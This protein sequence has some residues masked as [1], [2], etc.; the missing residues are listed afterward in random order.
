MK[1][2]PPSLNQI[3]SSLRIGKQGGEEE[4]R[5]RLRAPNF[6]PIDYECHQD[7]K[8]PVSS[9]GNFAVSYKVKQQK[10]KGARRHPWVAVRIW[11]TKVDENTKYRY[12]RLFVILD[13]LNTSNSK[14]TGIHFV[15]VKLAEPPNRG[16]LIKG[17]R[18]PFVVMEWVEGRNLDTY[19]LDLMRDKGKKKKDRGAMLDLISKRVMSL[20]KYLVEQGVEHGDL[21]PGN[22]IVSDRGGVITLNIIDFDS[23]YSEDLKKYKPSTAGHPDWQHPLHVSGSSSLYGKGSDAIAIVLYGLSMETIKNYPALYEEVGGAAGADGSGLILKKSDLLNPEGSKIIKKLEKKGGK[24][25]R[26]V[27]L[28]KRGLRDIKYIQSG[29]IWEEIHSIDTNDVDENKVS[30]VTYNK[31]KTNSKRPLSRKKMEISSID[32]IKNSMSKGTDQRLLA[33]A[34]KKFEFKSKMSDAK[35]L[36]LWEKIYQFYGGEG[37]CHPDIAGN[38]L[39]ALKKIRS[40]QANKLADRLIVLHPTHHS[41]V[42]FMFNRFISAKDWRR[43]HSCTKAAVDQNPQNWNIAVHHALAENMVTKG[44]DFRDKIGSGL[45]RNCS[46]IAKFRSIEYL[47]KYGMDNDLQYAMELLIELMEEM[48]S[49]KSRK[50][51]SIR[52]ERRSQ[53]VINGILGGVSAAYKIS[54]R[55]KTSEGKSPLF[56]LLSRQDFHLLFEYLEFRP[57]TQYTITKIRTLI[58]SIANSPGISDEM[59]SIAP[60]LGELVCWGSGEPIKELEEELRKSIGWSFKQRC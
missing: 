45:V 38:Y 30:I 18:H 57:S 21:S 48:K 33:E 29:D 9:A 35:K 20:S 43:L 24:I 51:Y 12:N 13:M 1:L 2:E 49:L 25:Q 11:F 60:A 46:W 34:V 16:I 6:N 27:E 5:K 28:L 56:Q 10:N 8:T 14:P 42:S 17:K 37:G 4:L 26:W 52:K 50:K 22:I 41:I 19:I 23:I 47:H 53:H 39:W 7:G 54:K 31:R 15:G 3:S 40:S 44:V 59:D 55:H 58:R 32:E 36:E